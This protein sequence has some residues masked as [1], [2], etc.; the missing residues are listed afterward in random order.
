[1][2]FFICRQ[3]I[4][5]NDYR[6]ESLMLLFCGLKM[7]YALK[8]LDN[9]SNGIQ[10]PCLVNRRSLD[11]GFCKLMQLTFDRNGICWLSGNCGD[12]S[13]NYPMRLE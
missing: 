4:K 8:I 5:Y 3:S 9:R 7:A 10:P 1:M 11:V 13:V 2:M 12:H 6:Y